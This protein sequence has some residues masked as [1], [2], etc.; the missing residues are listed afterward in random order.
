MR[1]LGGLGLRALILIYFVAGA[2]LLVLRYGVLPDAVRWRDDIARHAAAALGVPV[3]IGALE[4]DWS[5]L[6]PRL[7]LKQV[8]L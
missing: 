8:T 3:S 4:A 5:G 7:H 6:R 2:G 1:R